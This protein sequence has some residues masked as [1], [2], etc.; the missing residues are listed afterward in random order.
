MTAPEKVIRSLSL[1][2]TSEPSAKG[3]NEEFPTVGT[4]MANEV[5]FNSDEAIHYLAMTII[6]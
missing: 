6:A 1:R 2:G 4:F 3:G 5:K